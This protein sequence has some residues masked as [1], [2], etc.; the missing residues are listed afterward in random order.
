MGACFESRNTNTNKNRNT[1]LGYPIIKST[2]NDA[3]AAKP[4]KDL[5]NLEKIKI[6]NIIK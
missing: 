1:N 5:P 3:E 4:I 2:N 6:S